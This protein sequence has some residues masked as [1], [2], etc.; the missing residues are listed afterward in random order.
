[1]AA[2]ETPQA[3]S[4]VAD[5]SFVLLGTYRKS[6][7]IVATPVWVAADGDQLVV[8]T[9]RST[10]K[11]KRLR[12]DSRVTLQPCSRMGKAEPDSVVVEGRAQIA[13]PDSGQPSAVKALR[14]KYK[15][16]FVLITGFERF[17]RRVQRKPGDRVIVRISPA[18]SASA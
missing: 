11:V 12:N 9:E 15:L 14:G 17:M 10:G 13:G 5:A 6:G 8:T 4:T 2:H 16:E 18:A 7:E 1:M 3:W